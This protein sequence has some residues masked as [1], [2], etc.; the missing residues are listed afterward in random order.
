MPFP[1]PFL[2]R[3]GLL[4]V[5]FGAF[6]SVPIQ[7]AIAAEQSTSEQSSALMNASVS[8]IDFIVF[9]DVTPALADTPIDWW[10]AVFVLIGIISVLTL[11]IG[12]KLN[13][14]LALILSAILVSILVGFDTGAGMGERMGAVVSAFGNSAAG[15]GIVIAMAAIIGKCMLDSGS[16]DRIVR[17]AVEMTGEKKASLG[18]MISG[19]ILAIPV[20]FDTVFYL[21]VPLARSLHRRTGKNYL[22]YLMAIA[23]GGCITHTLV[24]PTPGPLLVAAILHVDIGM[25]MIIGAAVAIP[26][27]IIGLLFSIYSDKKS[28]IP[29]RP[30]GA[31]DDRHQPLEESKLPGL[32]AS[33]LPVILPVV[34]IGAGTL[35]TTLADREDR[36]SVLTTDIED[37]DLLAQRFA[38]A[39]EKSPAGRILSSELLNEKQ[40][41]RLTN[42]AKNDGEKEAVVAVINEALL[43]PEYYSQEAFAD[44]AMP[45]VT[46]Q[47]MKADQVRMKP[48]D[49]RRMNRALLDA[50]YPELIAAQRWE[51]PMRKTANSLGLWSNPN[52][53]LLLAALA[54]MLTFKIVRSLSWR[55]LNVDV[56]ESL[57][58]GGV[59]ILI[60]AAGGAF[61]A[62]LSQTGI[63]ETIQQ[64]F[65]GQSAS[66]IAILLLAWAVAAVLKVAQGSSTVA[67][68]VGAGMIAA[69]MGGEEPPFNMVYVATAV[70]SGS[71]MG[72]WMND[73][74]FWVFAKMG[75][76]TE[77]EA[78][79]TWTPLL[80]TLSVGGLITT[81]IL[82][83]IL[84][85]AG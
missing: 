13:A 1:A 31:N 2:A 4:L 41:S 80:A 60:T 46:A 52:F 26:S 73:S 20:F 74:G 12:L 6:A 37:F 57:M 30:L 8:S 71:L 48:V 3:F 58:S 9:G 10:P 17:T 82:S 38:S 44:V 68:I 27:A 75:G 5:L 40:R 47:L 79:K 42:A 50:A 19:F 49:R 51:S 67:M 22:R 35:A 61:G 23:T 14:F 56:E 70:G 83:Q 69:I 18:L 77:A 21:L 59:I 53:A 85:I 78:L 16:A 76:L 84:P 64:Y 33:L 25:M 15:V 34:L 24:P 63:G 11:I 28:P 55:E 36:A 72:S 45:D 66:G 65:S 54:A 81:I 39:T 62:M 32:F 29:M 43:D 7:S